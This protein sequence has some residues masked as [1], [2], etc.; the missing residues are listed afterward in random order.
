M[1]NKI[2]NDFDVEENIHWIIM[3]VAIFG[4]VF[5][6]I[7]REHGYMQDNDNV[8]NSETK[9]IDTLNIK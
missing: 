1:I 9:I 2:W 3:S 7:M 4:I 6:I 8:V 5:A